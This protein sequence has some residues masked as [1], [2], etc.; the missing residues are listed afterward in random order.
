ML[1]AFRPEAS[2]VQ[3]HDLS[4]RQGRQSPRYK[5]AKALRATGTG[6][7]LSPT[8]IARSRLV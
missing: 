7:L 6:A 4:R 1:R 2:R 8:P 3:C 5:A